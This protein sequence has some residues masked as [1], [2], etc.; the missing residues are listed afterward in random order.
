[1]FSELEIYNTYTFKPDILFHSFPPFN[2]VNFPPSITPIS[3]SS[4]FS[5]LKQEYNKQKNPLFTFPFP[6]KCNKPFLH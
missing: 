2:E 3:L 6:F 5:P 1:M 4:S